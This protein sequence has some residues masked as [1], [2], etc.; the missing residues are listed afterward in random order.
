MDSKTD[1]RGWAH[2]SLAP[3]VFEKCPDCR[4]K[5]HIVLFVSDEECRKCGGAGIVIKE[6]EQCEKLSAEDSPTQP[7]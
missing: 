7:E 6:Q 1:Q 2:I 3:I 5:G 4:G